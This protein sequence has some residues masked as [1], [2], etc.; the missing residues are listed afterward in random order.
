MEFEKID[1]L[2]IYWYVTHTDKYAD[3]PSKVEHKILMRHKEIY[4]Q[5]PKWNE[6]G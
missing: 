6:M 3:C 2:D 5:L 1:A 4:G